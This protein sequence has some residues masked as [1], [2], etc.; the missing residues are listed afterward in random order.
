M[1]AI[2]KDVWGYEGLYQVSN[3]GD[4]R[5]LPRKTRNGNGYFIKKGRLLKMGYYKNWYRSIIL[6]DINGKRNTH[7]VHRLVAVAF[8]E[9]PK[10]YKDINHKNGIKSDNNVSNLE[11]CTRSKNISHSY[12]TGLR[13]CIKECI[14]C[15]EPHHSR[16]FCAN[17]YYHHYVMRKPY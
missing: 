8:L 17:H 2:W 15:G 13:K 9:N 3:L 11:W 16:G 5:S 7:K 1:K 14:V 4:V 12:N 10:S 6:V